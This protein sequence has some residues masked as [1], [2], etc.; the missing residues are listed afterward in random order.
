MHY[1]ELVELSSFEGGADDDRPTTIHEI[2]DMVP[3]AWDGDAQGLPYQVSVTLF[4]A[5]RWAIG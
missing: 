4:V 1:R 3:A 2:S 5:K